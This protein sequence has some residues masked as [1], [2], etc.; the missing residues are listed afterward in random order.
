MYGAALPLVR[1]GI[2]MYW[3]QPSTKGA[4]DYLVTIGTPLH[5][6]VT[7]DS[8]YVVAPASMAFKV[9]DEQITQSGAIF[10]VAFRKYEGG[11]RITSW[12]WAKGTPIIQ[13]TPS[14]R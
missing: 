5:A 8:A 1:I 9:H 10:T 13:G 7:G 11:W 12:A 4:T 3:L 2:A 14:A 6:N